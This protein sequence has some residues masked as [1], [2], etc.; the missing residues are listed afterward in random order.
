MMWVLAAAFLAGA[1]LCGLVVLKSWARR[2]DL[3]TAIPIETAA[4]RAREFGEKSP[5]QAEREISER[6][7]PLNPPEEWWENVNSEYFWVVLCKNAKFHRRLNPAYS[8]RIPLGQTDTLADK[9]VRAPFSVRCDL[10]GN[11][12][13][14]MPS[15]VMRWEMEAPLSFEPHPLFRD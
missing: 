9:P 6:M 13:V 11:E 4:Q 2:E 12:Y 14:Y 5:N 8:H 15:D 3:L 10:C 7:A 1:G